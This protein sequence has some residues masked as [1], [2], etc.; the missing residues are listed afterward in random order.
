[1]IFIEIQI[2]IVN[3]VTY[4]S[5]SSECRQQTFVHENATNNWEGHLY[6]LGIKVDPA[7]FPEELHNA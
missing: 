2:D 3:F 4:V 7:W 6:I 1:M 5:K